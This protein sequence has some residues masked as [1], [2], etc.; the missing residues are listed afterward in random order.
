[1]VTWLRVSETVMFTINERLVTSWWVGRR[2]GKTDI[3]I[4]IGTRD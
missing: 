4:D 2:E 3:D 1:M